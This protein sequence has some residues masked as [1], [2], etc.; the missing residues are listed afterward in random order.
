MSSSLNLGSKGKEPTD[1]LNENSSIPLLPADSFSKS[2]SISKAEE[3][4][5]TIAAIAG[6]S[7][8]L[9]LFPSSQSIT[10]SSPAPK[11]NVQKS[12]VEKNQ[13]EATSSSKIS[14]KPSHFSNSEKESDSN[15]F[16]ITKLIST[17]KGS[18][19]VNPKN[20]THSNIFVAPT[21]KS[22]TGSKFSHKK[23][24]NNDEAVLFTNIKLKRIVDDP[25]PQVTNQQPAIMTD[26]SKTNKQNSDGTL[27]R[28]SFE[29]EESSPIANSNSPSNKKVVPKAL[30][31]KPK[32]L[33]SKKTVLTPKPNENSQEI[34]IEKFRNL[35]DNHKNI[36]RNRENDFQNHKPSEPISI[37][38]VPKTSVS[39][40]RSFQITKEHNKHDQMASSING[41]VPM[42]GMTSSFQSSKQLSASF[43]P[44]PPP[45]EQSEYR[46]SSPTRHSTYSGSNFSVS[47][48]YIKASPGRI[49]S[50]GGFLASRAST[51]FSIS[52]PSSPTKGGFVQSAM[53]KRENTL[54]RQRNNSANDAGSANIFDGIALAAPTDNL[55]SL[56]SVYRHS[57]TGSTTST[58]SRHETEGD[59]QSNGLFH[60]ESSLKPSHFPKN[61]EKYEM[62]QSVLGHPFKTSTKSN[63]NESVDDNETSV[64]SSQQHFATPAKSPSRFTENRTSSIM[65]SPSNNLKHTDSR[66][67]SPSRQT[68]LENALKKTSQQ[69]PGGYDASHSHH[70]RI[71]VPSSPVLSRS[72]KNDPVIAEKPVFSKPPE[73]QSRILKSPEPKPFVLDSEKNI[74]DK[75]KNT[76]TQDNKDDNDLKIDTKKPTSS[77]QNFETN[78]TKPT[79]P[80]KKVSLGRSATS[81]TRNK[82]I[83]PAVPKKPDFGANFS[84]KPS[85]PADSLAKLQDLRSRS[86]VAVSD[87]KNTTGGDKS[88]LQRA[89][90]SSILDYDSV[91]PVSKFSSLG[92]DTKHELDSQNHMESLRSPVIGQ[93]KTKTFENEANISNH[94]STVSLGSDRL[95]N[96]IEVKDFSNDTK[97]PVT[98]ARRVL[99]GSNAA[100]NTKPADKRPNSSSDSSSVLKKKGV[101]S[102]ASNL[103]A[104]L[105]RGNPFGAIPNAGIR[106]A[107]TFDSAESAKMNRQTD[108]NGEPAKVELT[109]MTKSRTKGPRGRR[110]PKTVSSSTQAPNSVSGR[111]SIHT[112]QRSRSLSPGQ[113]Q[114]VRA[115]NVYIEKPAPFAHKMLPI[116]AASGDSLDVPKNYVRSR[117]S[118]EPESD[119]ETSNTSSF[120]QPSSNESVVSTP[121]QRKP[122]PVPPSTSSKP[123]TGLS[124]VKNKDTDSIISYESIPLSA[125]SVSPSAIKLSSTIANNFQRSKELADATQ[126]QNKK[127]ENELSPGKSGSNDA[128]SLSNSM[129]SQTVDGKKLERTLSTKP[130]RPVPPAKPRQLSSQK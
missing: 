85:L 1:L 4:K 44:T 67:W 129:T 126:L 30:P 22:T 103:S 115:S 130:N 53:L 13:E 105:Q 40:L 2:S 84:T 80:A 100:Q 65:H 117:Y 5:R 95:T 19:H 23:E 55:S 62:S 28:D 120:Y 110:L 113:I 63:T 119:E 111:K 12:N 36:T 88:L 99:F 106:K 72:V 26:V 15:R 122:L 79:I 109:H 31:P 7:G 56:K 14:L 45:R 87:Q 25:A 24:E 89:S 20:D 73:I 41:N 48:S 3:I 78:S 37:S 116:P 71:P 27:N 104:A 51:T 102:F 96:K 97:D 50:P 121:K 108:D 125:R 49:G 58:D 9:P 16:E 61:G 57:R 101:S 32:S 93:N 114:R 6:P 39:G 124:L 123:K 10:K 60:N 74:F 52:R 21:L 92:K 64:E 91:K 81:V 38:P 77:F 34:D 69:T 127:K 112:R 70:N 42:P 90:S 68:W 46:F 11:S 17:P 94:T 82:S 54:A 107:H 75:A 118:F 76:D 8:T 29:D 18:S 98:E 33:A 47:V 66:R 35:E 59:R 86:S 43:S 128:E 83:P